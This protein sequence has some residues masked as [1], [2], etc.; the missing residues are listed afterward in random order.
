MTW[1]YASSFKPLYNSTSS[2]RSP[3][4]YLQP[5][6]LTGRTLASTVID[7]FVY[8]MGSQNLSYFFPSSQSSTPHFTKMPSLLMRALPPHWGL[9]SCMALYL[10]D[11]LPSSCC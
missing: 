11:C 8:R 2:V 4:S 10:Q 5:P 6:S 3:I 1:V 7:M 9:I